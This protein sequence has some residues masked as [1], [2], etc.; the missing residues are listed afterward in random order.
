MHLYDF[1]FIS[2]ALQ[3][4][5]EKQKLADLMKQ[6]KVTLQD[7]VFRY[8]YGC[9][10]CVYMHAQAQLQDNPHIGGKKGA[11]GQKPPL[12]LRVLHRI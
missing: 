3:A 2:H 1:V 4:K 11:R 9:I 7:N 6:F 8:G 12:I 10:A 5:L